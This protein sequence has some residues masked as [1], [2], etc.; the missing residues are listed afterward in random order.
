MN[1]IADTFAQ[2]AALIEKEDHSP[3]GNCG[4]PHAYAPEDYAPA[5]PIC[6][7]ACCARLF[8]IFLGGQYPELVTTRRGA[9]VVSGEMVDKIIH[10]TELEIADL[11]AK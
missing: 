4:N 5:D 9:R 1:T 6:V 10:R 3:C 2:L 8:G 7:C 11:S